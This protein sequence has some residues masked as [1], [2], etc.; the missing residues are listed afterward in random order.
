MSRWKIE[1][2]YPLLESA[3]EISVAVD[4][5][6][7]LVIFGRHINGGFCALPQEGI[8]CELSAHDNFSDI[9]YNTASLSR[10]LKS[11]AKAHAIAEVIHLVASVHED[12]QDEDE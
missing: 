1:R 12:E 3:T 6:S 2:T 11:K 8:S 5:F 4:G 10:V 9:G 7:Y